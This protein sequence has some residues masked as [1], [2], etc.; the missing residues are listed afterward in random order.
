MRSWKKSSYYTNIIPLPYKWVALA[1][2]NLSFLL[3]QLIMWKKD[4]NLDS[5]SLYCKYCRWIM[6]YWQRF[7]SSCRS[8]KLL[9]GPLFK[10]KEENVVSSWHWAIFGIPHYFMQISSQHTLHCPPLSVDASEEKEWRC[11]TSAEKLSTHFRSM[12]GSTIYF[13]RK[14]FSF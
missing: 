6:I 11:N 7:S 3:P 5:S 1:S 10:H 13:Y 4:E 2:G 12:H 9:K 8:K 14:T